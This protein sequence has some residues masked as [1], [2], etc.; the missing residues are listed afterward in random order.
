MLRGHEKRV[1]AANGIG[2]GTGGPASRSATAAAAAATALPAEATAGT[3]GSAA[4]SWLVGG[5]GENEAAGRY[6]GRSYAIGQGARP[7]DQFSSKATG[8]PAASSGT[9]V[10]A[11]LLNS[12]SISSTNRNISSGNT[13]A[14]IGTADS[15]SEVPATIA[16]AAASYEVSARAG[17]SLYVPVVP[18]TNFEAKYTAVGEAVYELR[19]EP[20]LTR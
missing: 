5:R 12:S 11:Q 14:S 3:A 6:V 20:R 19:L 8:K 16:A 15:M 4:L 7:R 17:P 2:A 13:R 10:A 18:A 9:E 1:L